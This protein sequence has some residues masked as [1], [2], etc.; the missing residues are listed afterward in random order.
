M[1]NDDRSAHDSSAAELGKIRWPD[2][3]LE[4]IAIDYESVSITVLESDGGIKVL[5]ADGYVG[6]NLVGF[7]DEVVIECAEL[8]ESHPGLDA[9]VESMQR[10]LGAAWTGSG[11]PAR[12]TRNWFALVILLSDGCELVVFAAALRVET[13]PPT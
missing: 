2:A 10:R 11:S 6:C 5:R 1:G 7:W 12:N 3:E 13:R 4:N 8:R 9:C